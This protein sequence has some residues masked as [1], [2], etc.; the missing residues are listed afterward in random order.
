MMNDKK[1]ILCDLIDSRY[2]EMKRTLV[3]IALIE[4]PSEYKEGVDKVCDY[5]KAF[6]EKMEM[7]VTIH[8]YEKAGNTLVAVFNK[9]S[10]KKGVALMGHMDTVHCVGK[11]GDSP[12]KTDGDFIYGPGVFDCKGGLVIALYTVKALKDIGYDNRPVKLIFSGD[13]EAGHLLSENK[14]AEVFC[15]ESKDIMAAINCESGMLDGRIAV[16]RKGSVRYQIDIKGI[17]AHSGND[18]EKGA[19]AIREAAYKILEIEKNTDFNG[20]TYSCGV[21]SGGTLPNIIPD[22]CSFIVDVRL[23]KKEAIETSRKLL[24][25][26]TQTSYVEG[27]SSSM[28]ALLEACGPM[29]ETPENDKLYKLFEIAGEEVGASK[30]VPYFSGGGSDAFFT[31][32][33]GVPTICG[34]GIMGE[35]NH[36]LKERARLSSLPERAKVLATMICDLPDELN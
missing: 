23:R 29:E 9:N 2:E 3:E 5:I 7:D 8:E 10:G 33:M 34:A 1:A 15:Q 4:S 27:T 30:T 28:S 13:E 25:K 11:F 24:E 21:I 18:P 6:C 26:I 12:I 32:K 14:G 17:A 22:N 19:S 20:T 35:A 16:G 36:T 31:S